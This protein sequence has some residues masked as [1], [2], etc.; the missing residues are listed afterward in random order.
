M[1][2]GISISDTRTRKVPT[3]NPLRSSTFAIAGKATV[4][5]LVLT[6]PGTRTVAERFV[7]G[8]SP[9]AHGLRTL[10]SS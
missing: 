8:I 7:A 6:A 1:K 2:P 5:H 4:Q 10:A 3:V 9:R